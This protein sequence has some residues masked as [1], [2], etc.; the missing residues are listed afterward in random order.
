VPVTQDY[1]QFPGSTAVAE[2]LRAYADRQ[3]QW[4]W[5]LVAESEGQFSVC[6]FGSLLPYLTGRTDH[7][8]HS[9][10]DCVVCGG[11]APMLWRD[12]GALLEEA[13]ADEANGSRALAHL[14]M[15]KLP[16]IEASEMDERARNVW[17]LRQ[18]LR[19]CGVTE[20]G[21]LRGVDIMQMLGIPGGM[22]EF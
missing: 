19:V 3:G 22:P 8:V 4:W 10:G 14:P 6:S 16:T 21:L 17:M 15:A 20:D 5:L 11:M 7:I 9:I 1:L 2:A 13:L 12:T 18:R